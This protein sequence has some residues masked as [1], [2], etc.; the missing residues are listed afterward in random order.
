MLQLQR[1]L[2]EA[3]VKRVNEDAPGIDMLQGGQ[4]PTYCPGT[5]KRRNLTWPRHM[6]SLA[7]NWKMLRLGPRRDSG[8]K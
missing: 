3:D 7:K 5:A 6:L 1:V 4:R 8:T 2:K